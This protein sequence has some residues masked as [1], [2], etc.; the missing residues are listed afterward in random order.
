MPILV[1]LPSRWFPFV[2]IVSSALALR[3]LG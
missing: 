3:V 1:Q 2:V